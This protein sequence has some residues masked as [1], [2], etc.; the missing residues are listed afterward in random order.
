MLNT[1]TKH[2]LIILYMLDAVDFPLSSS[3]VSGHVLKKEYMDYFEMNRAF[4]E[5]EEDELV[6]ASATH[7]ST[8]YKITKHGSQTLHY[9]DD[10]IPKHVK[11]EIAAYFAENEIELKNESYVFSNYYKTEAGYATRCVVK[12]KGEPVFELMLNVPSKEMAMAI[13]ENWRDKKNDVFEY[14]ID[15]LVK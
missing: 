12:E 11:D 13:C 4:S 8:Q 14:L 2:K 15:M 6:V 5:L 1:G 10:K 3:Q 7:N 9:L